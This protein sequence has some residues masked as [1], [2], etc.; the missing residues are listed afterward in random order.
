VG[1]L[2]CAP[3]PVG[4]PPQLVALPPPP[5]L[6][7]PLP[8]LKIPPHPVLARFTLPPFPLVR[9]AVWHPPSAEGGL[10]A[11]QPPQRGALPAPHPVTPSLPRPRLPRRSAGGGG[12]GGESVAFPSTELIFICGAL[13]CSFAAVEDRTPPLTLGYSEEKLPGFAGSASVSVRVRVRP[14]PAPPS[15]GAACAWA[16]GAEMHGRAVGIAMPG[17][18]GARMLAAARC[19]EDEWARR[20]L[21]GG[22]AVLGARV[23]TPCAS[24]PVLADELPVTPY[25]RR[26]EPVW[27]LNWVPAAGPRFLLAKITELTIGGHSEIVRVRL[28]GT[29]DKSGLVDVHRSRMVLKDPKKKDVRGSRARTPGGLEVLRVAPADADGK[30][31]RVAWWGGETT[32]EGA[33]VVWHFADAKGAPLA[34]RVLEVP[35]G[36]NK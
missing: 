32:V 15:G 14:Q 22:F 30:I 26:D 34:S 35:W 3:P 13:D 2:T 11:P 19:V 10:R 7:A 4:P 23:Y 25:A 17:C 21:R 6:A 18:R 8:P 29:T 33:G 24:L 27:V 5:P 9:P 36:M 12:G 31:Y 28:D 20:S 16:R 1:E